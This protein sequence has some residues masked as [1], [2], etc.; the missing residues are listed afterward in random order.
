MI[1]ESGYVAVCNIALL[2]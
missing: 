1:P 2:L